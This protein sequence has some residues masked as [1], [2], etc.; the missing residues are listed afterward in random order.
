MR[1]W[2]G[3]RCR[4]FPNLQIISSFG[5]GYDHIDAKAW[6]GRHGIVVTNTPGVLND[7]V[8]DTTMRPHFGGPRYGAGGPVMSATA[9]WAR[10]GQAAP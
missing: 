1:G 3:R 8:A 2:T 10:E 7:E 5:V 4:V 6:A 9:R